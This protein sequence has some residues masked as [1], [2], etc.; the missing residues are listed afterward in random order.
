[1]KRVLLILGVVIALVAIVLVAM[2]M[3]GNNALA[4]TYAVQPESIAIPDDDAAIA[5]GKHLAEGVGVC[6]ICHG[7]NLGG[8]LAFDEFP[9]GSVY[10][11]NLTRG[12][13]GVASRYTDVDWVRAIRHGVAPNGRGLFFM[14]VDYYWNLNDA[15]L[16]ALIAYIKSVPPVDNTN[17]RAQLSPFGK[18]MIASGVSGELARAA[19]IDHTRRPSP[20]KSEGEYLVAIG[21]CTF[22]HGEHL[23]GGQGPEP[24]APPGPN[25]SRTGFAGTYTFDDFQKTL[26]TGTN[27]RG[28]AIDPRFMPWLGYRKMTD[29]EIRAVWDFLQTMP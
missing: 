29:A 8:K 22:C 26:R 18:F 6:V 21:G 2:E 23:T 27:P 9:I 10:T 20:P 25:L 19:K 4:K 7:E 5:R 1:M 16:G 15:D 14:P 17:A 24:G 11:P 12:A 3:F 13:G 28:K